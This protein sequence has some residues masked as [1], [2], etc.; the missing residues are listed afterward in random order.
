MPNKDEVV[1]AVKIVA[2]FANNPVVGPVKEILDDL[3]KSVD[4]EQVSDTVDVS[5]VDEVSDTTV[6]QRVTDIKE[7][8]QF[9]PFPTEAPTVISLPVGVFLFCVI[10][11]V[12]LHCQLRVST[13][14]NLFSVSAAG[15]TLFIPT[16]ENYV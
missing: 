7:T 13:T 12:E 2:D 16:L 8:R 4:N 3:L 10:I 14:N 6:E 5:V 9:S 1:A 11:Q 15:E